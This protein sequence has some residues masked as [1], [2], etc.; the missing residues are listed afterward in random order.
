M[1]GRMTERQPKIRGLDTVRASLV[2]T[3]SALLGVGAGL[4]TPVYAQEVVQALPPRESADLSAALRRLAARPTDLE[5]LLSAGNASLVLHDASAAAGF[6]ARAAAVAPA[7]QRVILGQAR[8]ALE[9][10]RPVDALAGFARAEQAGVRPLDMAADRGLAHDLVGDNARAQEL[11]RSV[12]AAGDDSEVR[13]RLALSLAIT[14]N[15]PEFE[16][17]LY[18]M[19]R[20]EDRS[21]YRTRAF[22]LAI[23]GLTDDAVG[24]ADAMMPTDLALRMA[25][26]LRY[27]PRLTKA[28]Q[29]AAG[30]LGA[31]PA[32]TEIGRDSADIAN[33]ASAGARIAARA[34]TSLTPAGAALGPRDTQATRPAA[35]ASGSASPGAAARVATPLSGTRPASLPGPAPASARAS[36]PAI[37]PTPAPAVRVA[38]AELPP[39]RAVVAPAVTRPPSP[40][41]SP[42][43]APSS[44]SAPASVQPGRAAV[45]SPLP[46][47]PAAV[48]PSASP[49]SG[50]P[51]A[52][53]TAAVDAPAE[54]RIS[55]AEAFAEFGAPSTAAATAPAPDAV[56]V[57]K[58]ASA[59]RAEEARE[60]KEAD[61]RARAKREAD[62]KAA[63]AKAEKAAKDA[64]PSRRW[65]QIGV[66]R[67]TA[68]F[69][70]DWK[71]LVKQGGTTL[72]GKGPWAVKYGAS[73][74]ML[75]GPYPSEA[76][77]R[78]ALKALKDKGIDALPYTSAE[79]EKVTKAD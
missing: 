10:R 3:A 60:R 57:V 23:L 78:A 46:S 32:A 11:Y 24:I 15:R 20:D 56:D 76:A 65:L 38:Q 8:V 47:A 33:Y 67:N 74:R 55:L 12:L 43:P 44:A 71:R 34:D 77:A 18:P 50:P 31:F 21:A 16:R 62:A 70:F 30:N 54:D 25:P 36:G 42:A 63:K 59:R 14:G 2:A 64:E 58:L 75:A 26:Y 61:A 69:A 49:A 17:T 51:P 39:A 40:A 37:A 27:M 13:R 9:Q 1:P 41:P 22:G 5:A 7:D 66:G 35:G 48:V 6:F 28:Q 53:A 29:A 19:L 45:P 68:A 73:N 72:S 4:I 79:G 52:S